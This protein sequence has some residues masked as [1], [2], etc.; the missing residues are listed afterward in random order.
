MSKKKTSDKKTAL[1]ES[2]VKVQVTIKTYSGKKKDRKV[3]DKVAKDHKANRQLVDLT[4]QILTK[5]FLGKPIAIGKKFRNQIMYKHTLPWIDAD[6]QALGGGKS[7]VSNDRQVKKGEWR[8]LPSTKLEWFEEQLKKYIKEFND[9]VQE[10]IDGYSDAIEKMKAEETGL[11]D[12]FKESDYLSPDQ[13]RDRYVF[14]KDVQGINEFNADDIR[15]QIS[16]GVKTNIVVT[17]QEREK[18]VREN[19]D[20]DT[21]KKLVKGIKRLADALE[22]YDPNDKGKHPLRDGSYNDLRDML[23]TIDDY[24]L[25]DDDDLKSTVADLQKDI[26]KA[27]SQSNLKKDDKARKSTTKKLRKAEKQ[28]KVSDTAKGLF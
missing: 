9:A 11:G 16:E 25:T 19:A 6:D 5:K 21:A 8:I 22:N 23:D 15:I 12:L 1:A 26:A 24:L 2:C 10:I 13:L 18:S 4:K 28:V 27:K 3:R 17:A 20:K 14:E 7:Y